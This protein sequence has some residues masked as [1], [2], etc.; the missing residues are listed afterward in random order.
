[1]K[2]YLKNEK[3]L[4]IVEV[5]AVIIIGSIIMLL[6]FNVHLFSQKQYKSQSEKSRHLYD[7]TYAAKVITKEIRKA[8]KVTVKDNMLTL[9]LNESNETIFEWQNDTIMK[10]GNSFILEISKFEVER[11][12][13]DDR[14]FTLAIESI[15]QNG[16]NESIKTEI[17]VRE[18]VIIE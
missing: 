17:Y 18:G 12:E 9:T 10:D 7:V 1:M 5:L 14:K 16:K 4:T 13:D 6:I 15:E 3:G 11:D 2:K 8:E